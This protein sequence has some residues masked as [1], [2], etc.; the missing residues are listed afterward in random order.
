MKRIQGM[1]KEF[2]KCGT[3]RYVPFG[4]A[5]MMSR[6]PLGPDMVDVQRRDKI[7]ISDGVRVHT[8]TGDEIDMLTNFLAVVAAQREGELEHEEQ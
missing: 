5:H 7:V 3:L 8:I 6:V 2:A 4:F 1:V